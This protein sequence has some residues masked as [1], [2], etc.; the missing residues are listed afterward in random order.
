[1]ITT[2]AV[3][4][5]FYN[6]LLKNLTGPYEWGEACECVKLWDGLIMASGTVQLICMKCSARLEY[7]Y[8]YILIMIDILNS[9]EVFLNLVLQKNI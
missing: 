8:I 6:D 4:Y 2:T 1:M 9:N 5:M 7:W 3:L